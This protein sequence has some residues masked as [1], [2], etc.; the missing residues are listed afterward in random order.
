MGIF[1][2]FGGRRVG[3]RLWDVVVGWGVVVVMGVSDVSIVVKKDSYFI[4]YV[5]DS[6]MLGRMNE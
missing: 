4:V 5:F 6:V 2:W 1:D 3:V